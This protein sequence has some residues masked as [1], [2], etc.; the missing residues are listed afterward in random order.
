[1]PLWAIFYCSFIFANGVLTVIISQNRSNIYMISQLL[2]TA[3]AISFFFIYYGVVDKPDNTV[4]TLMILFILFQEIWV[5]KE[6][7]NKLIYEQIPENE[8]DVTLISIGVILL[9]F[10]LPFIYIIIKVFNF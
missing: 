7:Y 5:N 9:I 6:L 3:L 1:M 8:R 2:S 10:L 4:L